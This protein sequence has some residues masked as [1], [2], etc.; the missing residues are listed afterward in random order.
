MAF[1]RGLG[2]GDQPPVGAWLTNDECGLG[3]LTKNVHSGVHGARVLR[4]RRDD[5]WVSVLD[6]EHL[7]EK[8]AAIGAM[9]NAMAEGSAKEAIPP[10]TAKRPFLY[11]VGDRTP[12]RIFNMLRHSTHHIAAWMLNQAYLA[13][14]NPDANWASD[15]QTA[16]F[17]TRI[18]EALLLTCF[19]EQ[20]LLTCQP[21]L[22]PDFHISNR[23]G[24]QAWIEAVTANPPA[25]YEHVNA[26]ITVAPTGTDWIDNVA[27]ER[28]SKT[29]RTKRDR[30][31]DLLPH[32]A[33]HPFAIAIADFQAGA[34]MVWSRPALMAYLYATGEP[35][36]FK[37]GHWTVQRRASATART[38]GSRLGLF[39]APGAE[40][41]SAII[42]SNA[43][44]L[45]KFNRVPIS[46]GALPSNLRYIRR[47]FLEDP[48][49]QHVDGIP[50]CLDVSSEAYRAMWPIGYEPWSAELEVFHN[51]F[52][53][54]PLPRSLLPE[55]THWVAS[56]DDMVCYRHYP[57]NVLTSRTQIQKA[58][59]PLPTFETFGRPRLIV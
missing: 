15:C 4:R 26:P 2:F 46:G 29:I 43:A 41:V 45:G 22:S 32:V 55:A 25:P 36:Q 1:P 58:S 31:Y 6:D 44:T 14:P 18:W 24:E 53:Q 40:D 21:R 12:S 34:S 3:V 8:Q 52:A 17:H 9:E 5:V 38:S 35:V 11:D 57:S 50:F 7:G 20:G 54:Y 48:S 42:F 33:G 51:P 19:R 37:D 10:G 30:R 13:L 28:F 56:E 47:G 27:T 16:N 23:K 39:C 49:G 59:D